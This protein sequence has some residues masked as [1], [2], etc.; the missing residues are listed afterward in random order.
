MRHDGETEPRGA[1]QQKLE[2]DP[3]HDAVTEDDLVKLTDERNDG[4]AEREKEAA[5]IA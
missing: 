1:H 5:T 2:P 3:D 4:T